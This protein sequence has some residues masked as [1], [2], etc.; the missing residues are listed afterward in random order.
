LANDLTVSGPGT[1]TYVRCDV[2]ESEEVRAAIEDTVARDGRLDCLVNNAA[3]FTGFVTIDDVEL[4]AF[5]RLLR[6]NVG[7]YFAASKFALPHLRRSRG[8][9]VNVNSMAGEIGAWHNSAYA[10]TKGAGIALTKAL[11]IDEAESGVRVNGVL[12]G[13]VMTESRRNWDAAMGDKQGFTEWAESTQWLG[14]S[15]ETDEIA[16]VVLFLASD[17]ASFITGTNVAVSGGAELGFGPRT[18]PPMGT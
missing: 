15:A 9:I 6:V 11:A 3:S 5:E 17:A 7:A 14:R 2:A 8:S 13:N 4:D 1:C 16:G 12:P 18:G 10:A